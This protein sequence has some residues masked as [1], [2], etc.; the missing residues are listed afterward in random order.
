MSEFRQ[1]LKVRPLPD[2]VFSA[3]AQI[4]CVGVNIRAGGIVIGHV[5]DYEIEDGELYL[6]V[7]IEKPVVASELDPFIWK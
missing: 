7:E 6:V 3:D 5:T 2:Q 4:N 1:T